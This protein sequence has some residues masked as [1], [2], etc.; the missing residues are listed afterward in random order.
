MALLIWVSHVFPIPIK[1]I[2]CGIYDT[3]TI[4]CPITPLQ[5][6]LTQFTGARFSDLGSDTKQRPPSTSSLSGRTP[7]SRSESVSSEFSKSIDGVFSPSH[8]R[9]QSA[10]S[11]KHSASTSDILSAK[12]T[13]DVPLARS[14]F[15]ASD[16]IPESSPYDPQSRPRHASPPSMETWVLNS[17]SYETLPANKGRQKPVTRPKPSRGKT[18][19]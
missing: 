18:C 1:K 15:S 5:G 10:R 9:I 19:S 11:P 13:Y 7:G 2:L 17:Q 14:H 12:S 4:L 3:L 16:V 6:A 8:S